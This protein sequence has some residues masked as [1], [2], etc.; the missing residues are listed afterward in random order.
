MVVSMKKKSKPTFTPPEPPSVEILRL[1]TVDGCG[2]YKSNPA[3]SEFYW[4]AIT[5]SENSLW[6]KV[7]NNFQDSSVH[8]TPLQEFG[9]EMDLWQEFFCGFSNLQ[10]YSNWLFNPHWRRSFAA[11]GVKMVTYK[12]PRDEVKFGRK[13]IL[14]NKSMATKIKEEPLSNYL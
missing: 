10:Q 2:I 6:Q 3:P 7:T 1:E 11:H 8:P 14:F 13:Q 4:G 5:T 12:V 9:L